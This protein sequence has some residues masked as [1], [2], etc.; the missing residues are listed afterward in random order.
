MIPIYLPYITGNEKK[1]LNECIDSQWISS[2]GKFVE[3]F[4]KSLAKFH[5]SKYCIATSNCTSALHLSIKSLNIGEGDEIICPALTFI[6]P[7]NMILLSGAKLVL[8][9]IDKD[10]MTI[11]PYKIESKITKKTKAIVVVHQFGHSAHMKEIIN[12][13][14]K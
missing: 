8:V 3:R 14:K 7:A 11:D 2:Q 5:S 13:A 6:A 12:L 4:E 9:D 1:Y 10:T